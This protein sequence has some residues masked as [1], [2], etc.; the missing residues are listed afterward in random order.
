MSWLSWPCS[1]S[2]VRLC[3]ER[4]EFLWCDAY[5]TNDC[6]A[7]IWGVSKLPGTGVETFPSGVRVFRGSGTIVGWAKARNRALAHPTICR[8]ISQWRD[9]DEHISKAGHFSSRLLWRTEVTIFWFDILT[10]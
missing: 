9:T 7:R 5:K 6:L 3:W 2:W 8:I 1:H 4:S 10:C